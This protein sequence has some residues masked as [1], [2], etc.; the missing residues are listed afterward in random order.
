MGCPVIYKM[1]YKIKMG[2]LPMSL[3]AVMGL[4]IKPS[5]L[6]EQVQQPCW[7]TVVILSYI[8][9][10]VFFIYFFFRSTMN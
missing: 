3:E 10:L 5:A 1:D 9:R 6:V 7:P 2:F 4:G 8:D